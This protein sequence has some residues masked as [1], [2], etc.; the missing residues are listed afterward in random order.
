MV[1]A[2]TYRKQPLL[3]SAGRLTL[4]RDALFALAEELGWD[5][6]AWAVLPNHYHFVAISPDQ[7][8]TLRSLVR[9]LHSA[10]AR[11][12]NVEDGTLG[13]RVWFQYWDSRITFQKS[14]FARLKYVHTNPAYHGLVPVADRYQ[15]CSAAWFERTAQ[16]SFVKTVMSFPI[17]RLN[18]LDIQCRLECGGMPPP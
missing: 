10:T 1:T 4:V 7:P 9:R 8:E 2:A 11:A 6:Q 13:R 12:V 18:V 5:L 15:W 3:R 17:D 14:Y 16:P